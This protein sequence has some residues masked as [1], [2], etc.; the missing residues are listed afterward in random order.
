MEILRRVRW[1]TAANLRNSQQLRAPL[2]TGFLRSQLS[3]QGR[4]AF[5]EEDDRVAANLERLERLALLIGFR[6]VEEIKVRYGLR[7]VALEIVHALGINLAVE[8]GMPGS[9]LLHE[10][11][12]DAGVI[13]FL[14]FGG[15]FLEHAV[16][17]RAAP[18][19]GN[20]LLLVK[21]HRLLIH[22]VPSL[23]PRIQDSEV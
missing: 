3:C 4:M 2:R 10:L 7:N 11:G 15:Q 13:S 18:P 5:G 19:L 20:D 6:I 8:N 16:A 14:P 1:D 17:H 21:P 9:A 22:P 23:G 12:E